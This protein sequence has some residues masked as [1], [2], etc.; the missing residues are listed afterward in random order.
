MTAF[1]T[2]P[3]GQS[4]IST[5]HTE[6]SS[7]PGVV[8]FS[9]DYDAAKQTVTTGDNVQ[10]IS[11]PAGCYVE[12]VYVKV[13]T[14]DAGGAGLNV[15]DGTQAAGYG[16]YATLSATGD[17]AIAAGSATTYLYTNT[18][19]AKVKGKLVSAAA[20]QKILIAPTTQSIT[21]LKVRVTVKV[22]FPA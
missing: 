11:L 17:L 21:T 10:L 16:A 3:T 9:Q 18:T 1:V 6:P 14:A 20:D 22:T 8:F 12:E 4:T 2:Y 5:S 15:G 19:N 7:S 13:L